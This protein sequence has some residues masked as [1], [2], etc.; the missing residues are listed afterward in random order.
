MLAN[1]SQDIE[2][3][4]PLRANFEDAQRLVSLLK[5]TGRLNESEIHTFA[6]HEKYEEAVAGHGGAVRGAA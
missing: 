6:K 5:E 3:E 2:R 1:I 4:A